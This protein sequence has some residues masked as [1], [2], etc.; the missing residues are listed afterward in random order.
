MRKTGALR[1]PSRIDKSNPSALVNVVLED[2]TPKSIMVSS[3]T[4]TSARVLQ[5]TNPPPKDGV[6]GDIGNGGDEGDDDDTIVLASEKK[7]I[8]VKSLKT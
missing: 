4:I 5:M 8:V 6:E 1:G 2:G 7:K 3:W